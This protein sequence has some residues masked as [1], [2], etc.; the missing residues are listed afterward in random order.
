LMHDLALRKLY[1]YPL[2]GTESES[3]L[4]QICPKSRLASMTNE[5]D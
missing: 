3:V 1:S 4:L 5:D 2:E